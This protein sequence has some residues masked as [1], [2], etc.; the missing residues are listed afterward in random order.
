M[1][2]YTSKHKQRKDKKDLEKKKILQGVGPLGQIVVLLVE[3]ILLLL[4]MT[5]NM[6]IEL[7][8]DGF[9]FAFNMFFSDFKGFLNTGIQEKKGICFDLLIFRTILT[10]MLPPLGVFLARGF[11]GWYNIVLCAIFCLFKYVPGVLYA[12]V[13]IHNAR[14]S[15]LYYEFKKNKRLEREGKKKTVFGDIDYAP[16]IVFA[17]CLILAIALVSYTMKYSPTIET[18]IAFIAKKLGMENKLGSLDSL[19]KMSGM[20]NITDTLKKFNP[21]S[22][23]QTSGLINK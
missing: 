14:Y 21:V 8:N 6:F 3:S 7:A 15:N 22:R 5:F 4:K 20:N 9:S 18:D 17:V 23:A 11:S 2:Y 19:K 13:V 10:V 12:F 1:E 16:I